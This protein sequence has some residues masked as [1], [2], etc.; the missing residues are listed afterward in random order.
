MNDRAFVI[1]GAAGGIGSATARLLA[2]RGARLVLAGR[3]AGSLEALATEVGGISHPLDAT[4]TAA[5]AGAVDR[6]VLEFGRI[7]GIANCVGS[8]LLKPAHI[9]TDDEWDETIA[10]NLRSAFAAVRAGARAMRTDGGSIVLVSSA[11]AQIGLANH[12]AIAAAKGGISGLA[13]AAAASYGSSGVRVNA[14]APGLVRTALT[15]RLTAN[16]KAESASLA[17]HALGRLGEPEDVAS[18]IAFLL[19]PANS[20]ITGQILGVDGGLGSVRPRA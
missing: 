3:T 13:L 19:D 17:M 4:D 9:T 2:A 16:E 20:W 14:V 7:D 8:L 1:L 6:C 18:A 11:A 12:E 10:V 15:E 5:V